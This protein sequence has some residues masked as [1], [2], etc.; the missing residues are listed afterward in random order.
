MAADRDLLNLL[1]EL[2]AKD[3]VN[4]IESGEATSADMAN[5]LRLLKDNDV[6]ITIKDSDAL[7]ELHEKLARRRI[8]PVSLDATIEEAPEIKYKQK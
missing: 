1:L 3:L 7:G 2:T 4:R 5:A 8:K 6:T